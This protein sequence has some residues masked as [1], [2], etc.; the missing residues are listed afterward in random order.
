MTFQVV[1]N[2]TRLI[3]ILMYVGL[4]YLFQRLIKEQNEYLAPMRCQLNVFFVVSI[5]AMILKLV[6]GITEDVISFKNG[7]SEVL[8]TTEL[9]YFFA[10]GVLNTVSDLS[11]S[12]LILSYL[13]TS[14]KRE[15]E[16]RE[17][18]SLSAEEAKKS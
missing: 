15:R 5:T 1:N 3:V 14:A 11:F 4:L 10:L 18:I 8:N 17:S 7:D 6:A 2:V 12:G 16:I 13:M 9:N